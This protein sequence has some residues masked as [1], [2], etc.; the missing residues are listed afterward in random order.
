MTDAMSALQQ[1]A[2]T[3][4]ATYTQRANGLRVV[5]ALYE[6]CSSA[7]LTALTA[8]SDVEA[9]GVVFNV[10][11]HNGL[12]CVVLDYVLEVCSSSN[13][14]S[15][16]PVDAAL[17]DGATVQQWCA[18]TLQNSKDR[19]LEQ[20]NNVGLQRLKDSS[21]LQQ[22]SGCINSLLLVIKALDQPGSSS[23]QDYTAF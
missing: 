9:L 14:V 8:A 15:S 4:P 1:L 16:D 18:S 10:A 7:K 21:I 23:R 12:G 6:Q 17:L 3:A 2:S 19:V 13:L 20:L 22:E 5:R 11:L